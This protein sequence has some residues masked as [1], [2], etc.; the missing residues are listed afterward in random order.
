MNQK[1]PYLRK[2]TLCMDIIK[3]FRGPLVVLLAVT[4]L[5]YG[6]N[7][8][9][10][11]FSSLED[12]YE[13]QERT[14]LGKFDQDLVLEASTRREMKVERIIRL[15]RRMLI[16]DTLSISERKKR[17]LL[18]AISHGSYSSEWEALLVDLEFQE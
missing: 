3:N 13:V 1:N 7:A 5:H 8:Q 6:A 2:R 11:T 17:R 10:E 16:L 9:Q 4:F 14:I 12:R 15:K 18:K